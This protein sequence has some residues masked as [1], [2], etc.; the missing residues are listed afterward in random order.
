MKRPPFN[1][2]RPN[3]TAL[4]AIGMVVAFGLCLTL[5]V[6]PTHAQQTLSITE[7]ASESESELDLLRSRITELE[8][9]DKKRSEAE[10]KKRAE[11]AVKAA[12]GQTV[13]PDK[14]TIR[15]GGHV[16]ADY[17]NWANADSKISGAHDYFEFRRLRL[18]AEGTGY[19][20]LDF[21]L[22]LT[23]EPETVGENPPGT[24]TSS[25]VKDAYLSVN[26]V[27]VFGRVRIGN[28]F[29]PFGLEQVTNDTNNI[30]IERSIPT[31]GVFTAD[32]EVGVAFYRAS[33][34]QNLTLSGGAFFDGI[35]DASKERIDDNQGYRLSGRVTWLPY[36]DEADQGRWLLHTGAGILLTDDQD[37]RVRIR[38]RPQVHE[39]PRLID[40]GILNADSYT[41]GNLELAAVMGPLTLQSE[42]YLSQIDM[43]ATSAQT[44][45]GAYV[46]ASYFLTGESRVYER[47][48]QH[49]AQFGRNVPTK[50][51]S[52]LPGSEGPGAWELKTRWSYLNLDSLNRG[53]YNDL[54]AGVNW[55]WNDRVRVMFDWIHPVTTS[56][57]TFGSTTSDLLAM[58][59]DFNW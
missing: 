9:V 33:D 29:V 40:S 32:R 11:D 19:G 2:F 28:F 20:V 50:R 12:S 48:G 59:F 26:E 35:S 34:D 37:G 45:H 42:A 5:S 39:G 58:R 52:V 27:P 46:H 15:V 23:L 16:Q 25:E 38:A 49:G 3:R 7:S 14:W 53:Q 30:F 1:T 56:Q 6:S 31:Q 51:F 13:L 18:L 57:T 22:Q 44:L 43:K 8:S 36:Y 10:T 47:Y 21:R 41:T 24:V 4:T 55:Y 54:T 17:V